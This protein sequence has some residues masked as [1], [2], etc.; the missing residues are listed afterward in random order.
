M[1]NARIP[2]NILAL[3]TQVKNKRAKVVIEHIL[4]HGQVTTEEIESY[5]YKHPPRAARDVRELG[6]PLETFRVSAADGRS[7][8]AYRFGDRS[9]VRAGK[10]SG[11]RVFS[12]EL[13]RDLTA[14]CGSKCAVCLDEYEERYLQIDHRVPYEIAG[15][16]ASEPLSR[17]IY[18]LLCGSC[19]RAKS[20]S[21]EHCPNWLGAKDAGA[22]LSC[23]WASP[24]HYTHIALQAIR[25]L[26]LVWTGH[27]VEVL[28]ALEKMA[29]ASR[30][31]VPKYVK[32]VLARLVRR[33]NGSA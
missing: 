8:A 31:T 2:P 32:D 10:L 13:K 12:K 26:D 21:C 4:K 1:T 30:T 6:I 22:C 9:Q 14:T 27:E 24:H 19:N 29:S 33:R 16:A 20:W 23:Y 15:D 5:G 25:R 17:D 28:E 7:I 3:L 11:R 18:M